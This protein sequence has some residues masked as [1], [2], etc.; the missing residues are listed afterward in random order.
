MEQIIL[1]PGIN[2]NEL[3]R[4]LAMHGKN[5][6]NVRVCSANNLARLALMR[7]GIPIKENFVSSQEAAAIIAEAVKAEEEAKAAKNTDTEKNAEAGKKSETDNDKEK[8]YFDKTTYSDIRAITNAVYR[9]RSL[10]PG[11]KVEDEAKAIQNALEK[12]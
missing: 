9:M 8:F 2:G 10:V 1:A 6:F 7:S 11:G 5:C 4:S 12:K 3:L